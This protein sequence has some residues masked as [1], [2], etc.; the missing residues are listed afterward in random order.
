MRKILAILGVALLAL[1]MVVA[2]N[3]L[4]MRPEPLA[5]TAPPPPATDPAAVA[6]LAAAVRIPTISTSDGPAPPEVLN[7]FHAFLAASFP[8][9]HAQL[10]REIVA[11]HSLLFTWP[12]RDPNAPALLLAAHQDVVPIDPGS[13][14]KWHYPPFAGTVAGGYVWGRGTID[15]KQAL[16][17]ILEAVER[18]LARGVQPRQTVYLA[19]GH[20][21]ERGGTGAQAMAALL[22][23]RR[24]RIGLA[25]D[26]G[27]AVLDG[28]LG[29]VA[30]PV[31][32]IGTAEKGYL[33]VELRASGAGG[34]SSMPKPDNAAVRVA[35]AVDRIASNQMPTRMEGLA[36]QL[37]DAVAPYSATPMRAVFAN[38]WLTR[39]L[40]TRQF[41][42]SP[43]TAAMLRTTTA[44]TILQAGSKDNVLPQSAR[45]VINHRILPGDTIGA[46]LAH[47]RELARDD[48]VT[49]RALP[50]GHDPSRP[51]DPQGPDY[52]RLAATI[53][54]VFPAAPIAPGLVL[55][56][57]D[58][59]AY[60][61][62]ARSVLRFNPIVMGKDDLARFHGNDE[63]V[64]IANHMRAIA[65]YERL[66]GE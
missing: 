9:V 35:R 4:R 62:L 34:H 65:F 42:A 38:R 51:A 3:T 66:I 10:R 23:Q 56:A 59:R 15:D 41:L 63:R 52:R 24:A 25:M 7:A 45:A 54:A 40:I 6:R 11:G 22:R 31:A 27:F 17:A 20:D 43:D 64:S 29:F 57:T 50:G 55:G 48:G 26:E 32:V 46:V 5:T 44:V 28:V 58:G 47:D 16:V 36:G 14:R 13:E 60:E 30:R 2:V 18:M 37:L 19:F 39:P 49:V 8:R 53:R 21:E 61:G 12:G 33:S 1:V